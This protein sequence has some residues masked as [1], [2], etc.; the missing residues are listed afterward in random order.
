M[1]GISNS[2]PGTQQAPLSQSKIIAIV[3]EVE[4]KLA[5]LGAREG[6]VAET[7]STSQTKLAQNYKAYIQK[8]VDKANVLTKFTMVTAIASTIAGL[9]GA[10]YMGDASRGITQGASEGIQAVADV[11]TSTGALA[12]AAGGIGAAVTGYQKAEAMSDEELSSGSLKLVGGEADELTSDV[13]QVMKYSSAGK[14]AVTSLLQ[15]E[16]RASEYQG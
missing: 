2:N 14:S 3:D 8:Y 10:G 11:A 16:N 7:V 5:M 4:G 9:G 12:D 1:T 15:N 13:G 6:Q